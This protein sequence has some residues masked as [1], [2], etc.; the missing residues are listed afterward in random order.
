MSDISEN[1]NFCPSCGVKSLGGANFCHACG[2]SLSNALKKPH[3]AQRL[4]GRDLG[5]ISVA[6][7]VFFGAAATLRWQI[8]EYRGD[9][10]PTTVYEAPEGMKAP[11]HGNG[12]ATDMADPEL[13]KLRA[14]SK[15]DPTNLAKLKALATKYGDIF[16]E[17]PTAPST[18]AFEAI[19][20][21]GSILKI[22]AK[23]AEALVMMADISFDQ[24]AFS[25]SIEFYDRYLKIMPD[26]LGARARY[27]STL[28]FLGRFD[29]SISQLSQVLKKDPKNFPASAYLAITYAEKGDTEKA[30]E[31]ADLAMKLA[32]SEEARARFSGFVSSIGATKPE[33]VRGNVAPPAN[34]SAELPRGVEGIVGYIKNSPIAG[35]K[36]VKSEQPDSGTLKLFFREFPMSQMPPFAKEKFFSGIKAHVSEQDEVQTIVFV[37]ADSNEQL[38]KLSIR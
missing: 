26:D 15:E 28:T 24:K 31:T 3:F 38:E 4:S 34:D 27:A 23:N 37:D 10:R 14:A 29:E 7:I 2:F 1:I 21:L 8:H 20:T 22:D 5:L 25:K 30:K 16:R 17:N 6:T 18:L 36:F 35:P 13:D 9:K 19:D 33:N 12:E 32:P 11:G